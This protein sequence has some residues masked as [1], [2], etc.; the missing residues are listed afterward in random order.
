M[1]TQETQLIVLLLAAIAVAL[2]ARR[3][4]LPYTVGL[5]LAGIA[6]AL[7]HVPSGALLTHGLIYRVILPP[8]LFEAALCLHWPELRRD[9]APILTLAVAGVA[10]SAAVVAGGMVALL[11]WRPPAAAIFGVLIAATDPVSVIALFKDLR[12]TGRLRGLV[13]AE[14]LLNDGVAAVL[15]SLTLAWATS[16]TAPTAAG[17][18]VSLAYTA[19]GGTVLGLAIGRMATAIAGRTRDHLVE[20]ALT[21]L[22]AYG[23]FLGAEALHASGVLACVTAGL[24]IGNTGLRT[25]GGR[26]AA[27]DFWEFAAFLAN[28]LV[29][30][31]IGLAVA[32]LPLTRLGPAAIATT[33]VLV[34]AGR[35]LTVYPLCALFHRGQHAIPLAQQHIL[36][37]GGLRGALALALALGLPDTLPGH[38]EILLAS[39]ATV[40]FSVLVQ[41]VSMRT[42]LRIVG[43]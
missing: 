4:R 33:I 37:W 34:L 13:E 35:A 40:T 30:L 6:L 10:V 27:F 24:V 5:V 19:G 2:A 36:W 42:V 15:F 11:G 23:S 38:D 39:F 41:G 18:A 7:A 12:M 3:L 25:T 29:F 28:S 9:M 20:T 8:L 26:H 1:D 17:V 31:L 32:A 22:A 14:S 43:I 16:G 21:L